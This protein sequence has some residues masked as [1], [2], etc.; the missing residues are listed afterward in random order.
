[1]YNYISGFYLTMREK[2]RRI[3]HLEKW[4]IVSQVGAFIQ[5]FNKIYKKRKRKKMVIGSYI[6]V[7]TLNVNRLNAPSKRHRLTG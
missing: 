4:K 5:Q 3:D 2:A 1:M 7:I 6:L